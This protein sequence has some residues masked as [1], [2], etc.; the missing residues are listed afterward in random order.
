MDEG[1]IWQLTDFHQPC[2]GFGVLLDYKFARKMISTKIPLWCQERM[3]EIGKSS[4]RELGINWGWP[5]GF[6]RDT[7][8]VRRFSLGSNH[9]WPTLSCGEI[10]ENLDKPLEYLSQDADSIVKRE[11]LLRL[12]SLWISYEPVLKEVAQ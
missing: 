5:Y 10:P 8:F 6:Y 4:L 9:Q 1:L 7:S 3:N 12:F 11:G 2:D